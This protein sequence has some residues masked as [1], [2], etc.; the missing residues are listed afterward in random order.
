MYKLLIVDDEPLVQIGVSSMLDWNNYGITICG[1]AANGE[2]ALH[3]IENEMPDIVICDIKMPVMDGLELLKYCRQTYG[4][5]PVFLILTSYEEFQLAKEALKHGVL[6]YLIKL[7]LDRNSLSAAI[8][9][10]LDFLQ[11]HQ[12]SDTLQASYADRNTDIQGELD[13]FF[14]RLLHNLFEDEA[15]FDLEVK[16]LHLDF[17]APFYTVCYCQIKN[18]AL[19]EEENDQ[20]FQLYFSTIQMVREIIAKYL[21]CYIKI[22]RAHV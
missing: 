3:M 1:T 4:E 15:Q 17:S 20:L 8:Q 6:D 22:G 21:N 18:R 9:K 14:I 13:K 7:E 19:T 5:L 2:A 11:K 12:R 16:E 10:A